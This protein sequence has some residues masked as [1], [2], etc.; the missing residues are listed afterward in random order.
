MGGVVGGEK[1]FEFVLR[2]KRPGTLT[3][4]PIDYVVF[5]PD[6][7]QYQSLSTE[8]VELAITAV[9]KEKP[10]VIASADG[11]Q[12]GVVV[13]DKPDERIVTIAKDINYIHTS[14]LGKP[15]SARYEYIF[16]NPLVIWLQIIPALGVLLALFIS[17][18]QQRLAADAGLARKIQARGIAGRRLKKAKQVLRENNADSYYSELSSALR[19]YIADKCNR[20]AAGL[21]I[22]GVDMELEKRSIDLDTRQQIRDIL[23]QC[24]AGRYAPAESTSKEMH[25]LY[26][27]CANLINTLNKKLR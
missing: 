23:E 12:G 17:Q 8:P 27:K 22:E 21:T 25:T 24:D 4:P 11:S 6:N 18:R 9:K 20:P 16:R 13:T 3:V 14:G 7:E 19:G 1:E 10:L 26:E 2:P 5:N 15:A